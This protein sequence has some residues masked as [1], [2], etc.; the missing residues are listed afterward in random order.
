MAS[1]QARPLRF[2]LNGHGPAL[3]KA[4]DQWGIYL[5]AT[6]IT[7][8]ALLPEPA[9]KFAYPRAGGTNHLRQG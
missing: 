3:Q 4:D 6:V 9:H 1:R 8:E 5:Q 2:F 7:D